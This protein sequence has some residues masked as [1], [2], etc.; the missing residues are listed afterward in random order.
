MKRRVRALIA[1]A[2]SALVANGSRGV[3]GRLACCGISVCPFGQG[4]DDG[5]IAVRRGA[6]G[7][8]RRRQGV[9]TS[10]GL[11]QQTLVCRYRIIRPQAFERRFWANS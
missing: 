6:F 4:D 11:R 9:W 2:R 5:V 8:V 10:A 1:R 3:A 7:G